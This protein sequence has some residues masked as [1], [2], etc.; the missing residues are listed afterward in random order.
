VERRLQELGIELPPPPTPFGAYVEAVKIG[1]LF[2]RS[3]MLPAVRHEP[4][5]VGRLGKE[6]DANAA[7]EAV[8]LPLSMPCQRLG[9]SCRREEKSHFNEKPTIVDFPTKISSAPPSARL[10]V[11]LENG[12]KY[13][14]KSELSAAFKGIS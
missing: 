9:R 14:P 10:Q 5:F 3:G 1:N 2:F 12:P 8:R 4:R 7:R 6:L 11:G 13:E